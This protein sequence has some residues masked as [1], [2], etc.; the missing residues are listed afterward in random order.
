MATPLVLLTTTIR[1]ERK[2]INE[3]ERE[4]ERKRKRKRKRKRE[5]NAKIREGNDETKR[6]ETKAMCRGGSRR[7]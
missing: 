7:Y 5:E 2:R 6:T 1:T 4:R 3:I